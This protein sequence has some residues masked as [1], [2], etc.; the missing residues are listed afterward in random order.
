MVKNG[1]GQ[2]GHRV[3]KVTDGIKSFILCWYEFSKVDSVIFGWVWSK[4]GLDFLVHETL[5]SVVP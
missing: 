3:Q 1:C 5:I 2:S 4:N